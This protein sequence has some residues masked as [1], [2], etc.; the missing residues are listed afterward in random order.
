V[1]ECAQ[2]A[3]NEQPHDSASRQISNQ[4]RADRQHA[5]VPA[6]TATF[7]LSGGPGSA[8]TEMALGD[9]SV[10][11]TSAEHG[12][13]VFM[14]H[15]GTEEGSPLRCAVGA[16]FDAFAGISPAAWLSR[17]RDAAA[18]TSAFRCRRRMQRGC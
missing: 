13:V 14:D 3:V 8:A 10:Y 6:T 12:D 7:V 17:C 11:S 15:G 9:L 4:D 2:F 1:V 18:S 5:S 16:D